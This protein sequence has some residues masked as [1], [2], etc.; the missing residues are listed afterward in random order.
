MALVALCAVFIAAGQFRR[1]NATIERSMTGQSI[2]ALSEGGKARRLEAIQE[3]AHTEADDLPRVVAA[4]AGAL[5][6]NEWTL[7]SAA[8]R[9][10]DSAVGGCIGSG[11]KGNEAEIDLAVGALIQ[12]FGDPHAE[13]RLEAVRALKSVYATAAFQLGPRGNAQ[14]QADPRSEE[15]DSPMRPLV[16]LMHDADSQVRGEAVRVFATIG[17]ATGAGADPV[18]D[19]FDHDP[20]SDVRAA[21]ACALV[22]GW[23]DPDR[24]YPLLLGRLKEVTDPDQ[25]AWIGWVLGSLPPPPVE[26][27]PALVDALE[28]DDFAA[29]AGRSPMRFQA[30]LG[31]LQAHAALPALAKAASRDFTEPG[32]TCL[33]AAVAIAAIGPDSAEGQAVVEHFA[34]TPCSDPKHEDQWCRAAWILAKF[35]PSAAAT[36]PSLR[37]GLQSTVANVRQQAAFALGRIGPAAQPTSQALSALLHGDPDENVRRAAAD[38]LKRI[39]VE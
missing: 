2:R 4:L 11:T 8:V 18:L 37:E 38:A 22:S 27:I 32:G 29:F 25:R 19:V 9:S 26:M 5:G 31:P 7:R 33:E 35:G 3:L 20:V 14:H 17:P 16:R 28:L 10:L 36:V 13:V 23:P 1:D 30:Q 34:C 24:F 6:D 21:A 15:L 12:A 39:A